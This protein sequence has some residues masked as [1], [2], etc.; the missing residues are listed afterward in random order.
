MAEVV[1]SFF[2]CGQWGVL[3]QLDVFVTVELCCDVRKREFER[4]VNE[5]SGLFLFEERM[6][7]SRRPMKI[8]VSSFGRLSVSAV[9]RCGRR[10]VQLTILGRCGMNGIVLSV[11]TR[12]KKKGFIWKTVIGGRSFVLPIGALMSD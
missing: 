6:F 7:G 12:S 4:D 2:P 5:S 10:L 8:V 1:V 9:S 11:P 3:V